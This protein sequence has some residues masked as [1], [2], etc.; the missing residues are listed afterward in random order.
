M[1]KKNKIT[2]TEQEVIDDPMKMFASL[3]GG[4]GRS[5]D[6]KHK[7]KKNLLSQKF[8][9]PI[10]TETRK[11][12]LRRSVSYSVTL[13]KAIRCSKK[14]LFLLVGKRSEQIIQC[15]ASSLMIRAGKEQAYFTRQLV[16]IGLPI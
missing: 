3:L 10:I 7:D 11:K 1:K 12:I 16:M 13:L 8:F 4:L 9:L 6:Q 15:G 14:L 2:N 5:K